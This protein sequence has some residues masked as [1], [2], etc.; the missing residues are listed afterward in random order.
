MTYR[1]FV[2]PKEFLD[3]LK[4]RFCQPLPQGDEASVEAFAAKFQ[5]PMQI[6][7]LF[8]YIKLQYCILNC[9]TKN[10]NYLPELFNY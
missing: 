4:Q 2:T 7:F 5:K 1:S 9:F 3:L 8:Y 10:N 6:R